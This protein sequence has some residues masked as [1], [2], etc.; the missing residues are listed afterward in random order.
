MKNQ[1]Q[2]FLQA[3]RLQRWPVLTLA[4]QAE[5]ERKQRL[6]KLYGK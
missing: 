3:L 1:W 4:E 5:V 6:K 2:R